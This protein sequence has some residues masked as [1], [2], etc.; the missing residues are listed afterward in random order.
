LEQERV[1]DVIRQRI[2]YATQPGWA[3]EAY[4][5]FPAVVRAPCAGFVVFHSTTDD[6]I[7]RPAGLTGATTV[8]FA[9]QL[10]QRGHVALAPRNFLWPCTDRL[11]AQ[12][13]AEIYLRQHPDSTGL[14]KMLWD[15]QLALNI[16]ASLPLVDRA[17]LGTVGHSLGAKQVLYLAAFDA[18]VR[19]AAA[20]E[21]GIGLDFSNWDAP[22]Y[23][24]AA[25]RLG[26]AEHD[27]HQLL[28][29]VAPRAFLLIGG[30][31]A[32]GDRSWP[33]V[34]RAL[35][36]YRRL[37]SPEGARPPRIGLLNHRQGHDPPAALL[38]RLVAWLETYSA[39][40]PC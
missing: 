2:G 36:V 6:S 1:G 15:A 4:L 5:L 7:R 18:R 32:D 37:A 35:P 24:G 3:T 20:S 22:W 25:G 13:Q 40:P 14:A 21:G 16:L 38:D 12:G 8:D 26:L 10:A 19:V 30:E 11:D 39:H 29:L 9:W 17:R 28:A 33:F 23:W 34:E 31:S 27:H